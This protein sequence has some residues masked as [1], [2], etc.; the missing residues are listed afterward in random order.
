[1]NMINQLFERKKE[2]I[3]S[4]YFT[5]GYPNIDDTVPII[6]SLT[7][8]GV[9]MIEVGMPY[10]DPL[11][12][13][14][15]IQHSSSVAIRNGMTISKL[16]EQLKDLKVPHKIPLILMGYLNP[17]MQYG[18]DRF[19]R[20]AESAGISGLII[21]DLPLREFESGFNDIL[22]RYNLQFIFLITP[23]TSDERIRKMDSLA[24][25][26]LYAVSSSSVTGRVTDEDR[27]EAYFKRIGTMGL[28]NP[29]L[30]GFG[31]RDKQTFEQPCQYLNGGIVGT[32]FIKKLEDG[33]AIEKI[34]A[35]FVQSFR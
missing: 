33:G 20:D 32:S 34:T 4:V 21:P 11:A 2:K 31:I 30:A 16:F 28:K 14:P 10:S 5:A 35:G 25:S 22:K 13:G 29:V 3:L 17:V 24:D 18:V 15:V 7:N 12:D 1:M 27:K 8:A 6:N 19:C 23:E 26:F 9:D